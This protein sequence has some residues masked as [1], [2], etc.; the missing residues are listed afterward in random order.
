MKTFLCTLKGNKPNTV[1]DIHLKD[2]TSVVKG[3]IAIWCPQ[4]AV[5]IDDVAK[6]G[7]EM[8]K[9]CPSSAVSL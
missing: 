7:L 2:I 9:S 3:R 5:R 6:S 1:F 8:P 4:K